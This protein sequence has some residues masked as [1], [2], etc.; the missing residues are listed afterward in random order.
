MEKKSRQR[1]YQL[2]HRADGKCAKCAELTGENPNNG[3]P[4]YYCP[5]HRAMQAAKYKRRKA[6]QESEKC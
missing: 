2:R 4:Y 5:E 1:A 6:R 3:R